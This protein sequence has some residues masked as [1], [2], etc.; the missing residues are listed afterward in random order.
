MHKFSINACNSLLS[1]SS[2]SQTPDHELLAFIYQQICTYATGKNDE[3]LSRLKPPTEN[4][5]LR[6]FTEGVLKQALGNIC[7]PSA[8]FHGSRAVTYFKESIRVTKDV[9]DKAREVERKAELG[10]TYHSDG[11]SMQKPSSD[12]ACIMTLL[13]MEVTLQPLH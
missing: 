9:G 11:F 7:R 5:S 10:R 12:S 3:A 4:T 6:K 1:R 2:S 13:F 8:D